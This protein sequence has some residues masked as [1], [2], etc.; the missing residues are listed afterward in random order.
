MTTALTTMPVEWALQ[1]ALLAIGGGT[2]VVA[3]AAVF[4]SSPAGQAH[5]AGVALSSEGVDVEAYG[6]GAWRWRCRMQAWVD[7]DTPRPT[8]LAVV[9]DA[10][11][12]RIVSMQGPSA[13]S[14]VTHDRALV[15]AP[16]S[17]VSG[18][19]TEDTTDARYFELHWEQVYYPSEQ[20]E[21]SG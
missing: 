14:P 4:L 7:L 5:Q 17:L 6:L 21:K 16:G 1:D 3:D 11:I 13:L 9:V 15:Y 12:G 2:G 18:P 19:Q 20:Y 8:R 10:V